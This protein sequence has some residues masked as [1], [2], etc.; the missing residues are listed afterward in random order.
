MEP[1]STGQAPPEAEAPPGAA[2]APPADDP[3][4]DLAAAVADDQ[5]DIDRWIE[6][7]RAAVLAEAE[8]AEQAEA[9]AETPAA[10]PSTE[11]PKPAETPAAEAPRS[12]TDIDYER[13]VAE[14]VARGYKV[15]PPQPAPDPYH[16]LLAE[17][18]AD[19]GTDEEYAAVKAKALAYVPAEPA[20]YD[21]ESVAAHEAAV[22]ERNEAASKLQA[23]DLGRRVTDRALRFARDRT[24]GDLGAAFAALPATYDLPPERASRV[25]SPQ[26]VTD[27]VS[28][29][30]ET[31]TERLEAAH[32]AKLAERETYWQGEVARAK[33]DR[34]AEN[35]RRMGSAPQATA[36]PGA[37]AT[38]DPFAG[39]F[40]PKSGVSDD[41]IERAKRG[42]L[43]GIDLSER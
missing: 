42:E 15:E 23:Y 28:A 34:S 6:D 16:Q 4:V 13:V 18:V 7:A 33:T 21:A 5:S 32:A 35:L 3:P 26:T 2:A 36:V 27:A 37:R 22:R 41:V 38:G 10:A 11:P 1:D 20:S 40:D 31:V 24:L 30:V 8:S 43:A 29:I 17:L 14:M 25:T 9:T 19:R 39:L 12:Q